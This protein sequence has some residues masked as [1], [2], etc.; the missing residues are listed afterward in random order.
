MF[1][2]LTLVIGL[3]LIG[4]GC[5]TVE[6][7][8][9]R[10]SNLSCAQLATA[11][12]YEKN[13]ERRARRTGLITGVASILESGDDDALLEIDSD[14]NYFEADDRRLSVQAIRSEQ[15]RRCAPNTYAAGR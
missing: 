3:A 4:S 2:T 5:T 8:A 10:F 6:Q 12:D 7:R 15:Q 1:R 9:V 14:M 11:L 13:A